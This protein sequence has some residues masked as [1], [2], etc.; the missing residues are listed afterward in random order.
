M[1][2]RSTRNLPDFLACPQMCVNP[3][4][5]KVSGLPF[6]RR[7]RLYP[8]LSQYAANRAQSVQSEPNGVLS[9]QQLTSE[10]E[11]NHPFAKPL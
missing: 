2:L 11:R 5:L 3:R 6:P 9:C 10:P 8:N 1:V 4:K 7:F